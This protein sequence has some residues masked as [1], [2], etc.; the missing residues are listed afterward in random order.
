MNRHMDEK[1]SGSEIEKFVGTLKEVGRS[2]GKKLLR[3]VLY[4]DGRGELEFQA[5]N[6]WECLVV[7]SEDWEE[8]A[9]LLEQTPGNGR[10]FDGA[11]IRKKCTKCFLHQRAA[12]PGDL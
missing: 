2:S 12:G 7:A 4:E 9:H 5:R 1:S 3:V 11:V 6:P 10:L 8:L